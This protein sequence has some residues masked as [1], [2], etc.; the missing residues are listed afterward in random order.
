MSS[1]ISGV[2]HEG[3]YIEHLMVRGNKY[4]S[5]IVALT[6]IVSKNKD[7]ALGKEYGQRESV[8]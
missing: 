6:E 5:F 2:V 3:A 8:Q 1:A 4:L 7:K